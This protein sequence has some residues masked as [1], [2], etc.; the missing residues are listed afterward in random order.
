MQA[1]SA[2]SPLPCAG[3]PSCPSPPSPASLPL[4]MR[5]QADAQILRGEGALKEQLTTLSEC[6]DELVQALRRALAHS[7][8]RTLGALRG[9]PL[10]PPSFRCSNARA[11][12]CLDALCR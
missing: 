7:R 9:A 10:T 2:E 12:A 6:V 5:V 11:D 8:L 3:A 4:C 1:S